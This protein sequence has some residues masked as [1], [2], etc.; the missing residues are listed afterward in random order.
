MLTKL[1]FLK[2]EDFQACHT[3]YYA[4]KDVLAPICVFCCRQPGMAPQAEVY[5]GGPNKQDFEK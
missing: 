3:V 1:I 2:E 5:V 4:F